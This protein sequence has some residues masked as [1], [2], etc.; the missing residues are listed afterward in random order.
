MV[1]YTSE[2]YIPGEASL[3]EHMQQNYLT[4]KGQNG[5]YH[6]NICLIVFWAQQLNLICS[7]V[8][9]EDKPR[10]QNEC[11]KRKEYIW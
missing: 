4:C 1:R 10:V 5:G 8:T 3:P 7:C 9:N 11:A 6:H 2:T